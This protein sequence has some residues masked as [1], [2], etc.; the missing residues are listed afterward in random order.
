MNCWAC[1][2]DLIVVILIFISIQ[3]N[4]ILPGWEVVHFTPGA[5]GD[6][7][8]ILSSRTVTVDQTCGTVRKDLQFEVEVGVCYLPNYDILPPRVHLVF[9]G[10]TQT[11]VLDGIS[12]I[13]KVN[14]GQN[15]TFYEIIE[16]LQL[17]CGIRSFIYPP[18]Q[19]V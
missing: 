9:Q 13:F 10:L 11:G 19:G 17:N 16:I 2:S 18:G 15:W 14:V 12:N 3:G 7:L 8:L 1:D 4:D 5:D 6:L